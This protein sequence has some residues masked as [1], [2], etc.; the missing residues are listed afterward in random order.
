VSRGA[1]RVALLELVNEGLVDRELHRGARVRAVS[2]EEAIELSEVRMVIEGLC[3]RRAAENITEDQAHE[4]GQ[5][6]SLMTER[7]SEGDL[8]AY[9]G[10]NGELHDRIRQISRHQA[11][12]AI[13]ERLRNQSVRQQFRMSLVPGRANESA[14]EHAAIVEAIATRDGDRAEEEMRAHLAN[15]IATLRR[16]GAAQGRR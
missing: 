15:V 11:A 14:A 9:S 12:T 16:A 6:V 1:V 13:V 7:T 10:L 8:M 4:L 2:L 3:A 5:L